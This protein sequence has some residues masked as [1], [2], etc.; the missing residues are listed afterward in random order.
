VHQLPIVRDCLLEILLQRYPQRLPWLRSTRAGAQAGMPAAIRFKAA[1]IE[2]LGAHAL[3]A[4]ARR[5][6]FRTNSRLL[7]VYGFAGG[8]QRYAALLEAWIGAAGADDLIMCH[9]ALGTDDGD[10]LNRQRRAEY[11]ALAGAALPAALAR[12]RAFVARGPG[13]AAA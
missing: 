4:L 13:Q 11:A 1:L 10:P 8:E 6:G 2:V 5:H 12:H 7:G 9:P 3:Q